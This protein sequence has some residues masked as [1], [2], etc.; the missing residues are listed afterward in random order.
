MQTKSIGIRQLVEFTLKTGDL[1]TSRSKSQNTAL[2][3]TRIHQFLQASFDENTKKEVDLKY[4]FD[5]NERFQ[6]LL[7]GRA[8]GIKYHHNIPQEV[9]EIKTSSPNFNELSKNILTLYWAQC[10]IYAYLLMKKYQLPALKVTLLYFQ[11]T[12]EELTKK[13]KH[14]TKDA[15]KKRFMQAITEY[16]EWLLLLDKLKQDRQQSLKT[17][18]FP[19]PNYRKNQ[20]ELA[21]SVY[22]TIALKKQL[23]VEAPTGTGKTISTVFPALKAMGEDQTEKIFYLTAKESTR[24]TC[25]DTLAL[26]KTRVHSITLTAR[27][28]ITFAEELDLDDNQ[29]PYY[30]GYYDRL[31]PALKDILQHETQITRPV[32]EAYAK[33]HCVDPF[34]FSLDLSLFCD[35]IICDYNYLFDPM[36]YLQRFFAENTNNNYCFLI[37]EA[38][39][40]VSRSREMYTASLTTALFENAMAEVAPL[41]NQTL[42]RRLK[43]VASA[44]TNLSAPM[45]E[46]SQEEL[47]LSDHLTSITNP[48]E[49]LVNFILDLLP[50]LPDL[51]KYPSLKECFLQS[52]TFLKIDSFFDDSFRT[53]LTY[54]DANLTLKLF[55]LNPAKM[56]AESLEL[57]SACVFFS[58]TLS[59]MDYFKEMFGCQK[60]LCYQLPSP[61]DPHNLK[62]LLADYIDVTYKKRSQSLN[63]ISELL[64]S[65]LAHK[66]GNYLLFAPSYSYLKQL[67]HNFCAKYPQSAA[68]LQDEQ[69][70]TKAK[71]AFLANFDHQHEQGFV[72]FAVLGGSFAEGIDLVGDKLS[73]CLIV[74]VGLPALSLENDALKNYFEAQNEDGFQIAYQLPGLNNVFQAA[75]RVIRTETDRGVVC[76]VDKRFANPTY[77]QFFPRH[78]QVRRTQNLAQINHELHQ[79]WEKN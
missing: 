51:K 21:A 45:V 6:I 44:F 49:R 68:K 54:Q 17:L 79:F 63:D 75:G 16:E 70:D 29:N 36:V 62:I 65:M 58:A 37:D 50:S 60:A 71:E 78:W 27:D 19:F 15:A 4:S 53:K 77:Q 22:K 28:K 25:E 55:S 8:D 10:E 69:M 59:P 26:L 41:K 12:T 74:T 66:K 47:L 18:T 32:I 3:G 24:K 30:L 46:F 23:L 61:F 67:Y 1:T 72:G 64:N 56:L 9:I 76:L 39:N 40:L 57:G 38:H 73:G 20:Y 11:T 43:E 7:H 2:N 48:L 35:F 52:Y 34:E 31:R 13:S 14:L 33:K 42:N 5:F